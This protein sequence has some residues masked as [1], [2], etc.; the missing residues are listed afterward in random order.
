MEDGLPIV[1]R[2]NIKTGAQQGIDPRRF[3]LDRGWVGVGW[4][5]DG[6]ETMDWE[7]YRP[8]A[9]VEYKNDNGWWP[10]INAMRNRMS[11]NHLCWTRDTAGIYYLGRITSAWQYTGT[12]RKQ[13]G[14]ES[15]LR[16]SGAIKIPD[17][18]SPPQS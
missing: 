6:A 14:R 1:W 16:S 17:L 18:F 9:E 8:L 4:A 3:C 12:R 10:A 5:V 11:E 15:F 7:A 13:K 2:I